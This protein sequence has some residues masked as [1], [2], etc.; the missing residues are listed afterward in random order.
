MHSASHA[1]PCA[2]VTTSVEPKDLKFFEIAAVVSEVG[3]AA[4]TINLCRKCYSE[5]RAKEGSS[6]VDASKWRARIEQKASRGKLWTALGLE[7][8][9]C[10]MW[11]RF[12]I[13]KSVGQIDLGSCRNCDA[14]RNGGRWQHETP[15]KEELEHLRHRIDLRFGCLPMRQAYNA[16]KSGD[17]ANVLETFVE[18]GK[19][20][21]CTSVQVREGYNEVEQ[22]GE[23][24]RSVVTG[25]SAEKHDFLILVPVEGQGGVTLS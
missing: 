22:E 25:Q 5:R 18:N 19:F 21:V 4:R 14:V 24:R 7:Q 9:L 16:G 3:G 15:Y 11:E 6:E 8:F 1:G 13:Q 23:D 10:R 12:T 20:S 2:C 17:W